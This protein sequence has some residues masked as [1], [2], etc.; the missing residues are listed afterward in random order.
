MFLG[1]V[2]EVRGHPAK[3]S[4]AADESVK[5]IDPPR[6]IISSLLHQAVANNED[7]LLSGWP[8]ALWLSQLY[9][10]SICMACI[11]TLCYKCLTAHLSTCVYCMWV[12]F[13]TVTSFACCVSFCGFTVS[14][15]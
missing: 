7:P 13:V 4:P 6:S 9:P 11:M 3:L 5:K 10:H 8:D 15:S 1:S 14:M 12:V 2:S